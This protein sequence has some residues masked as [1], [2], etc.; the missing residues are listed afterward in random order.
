MNFQIELSPSAAQ[1]MF[2]LRIVKVAYTV[3]VGD[4]IVDFSPRRDHAAESS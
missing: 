4:G 2:I 1:P 3:A